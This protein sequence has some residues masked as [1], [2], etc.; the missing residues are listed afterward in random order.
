MTTASE[1]CE[2]ITKD[3]IF[4]SLESQKERRK[5]AGLK[6]IYIYT[7]NRIMSENLP[8]LLRDINILIQETKQ[9]PNKINSKKSM[10]RH[11]RTKLLKSKDK[12]S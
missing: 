5:K 8:N 6:Y 12:K 3:L 1:T 10:P 2:T 4:L 7:H 11:I 9:T